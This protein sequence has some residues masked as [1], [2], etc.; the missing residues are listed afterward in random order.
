MDAL[1]LI[2]LSVTAVLALIL[3]VM[4]F[5]WALRPQA[6]RRRSDE[7]ELNTIKNEIEHEVT[8]EAEEEL[9]P[10]KPPRLDKPTKRRL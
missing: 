1:T 8:Q 5:I 7:E 6:P 2:F 10:Y 3:V 4:I 9:M